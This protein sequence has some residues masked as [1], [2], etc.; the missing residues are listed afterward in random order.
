MTSGTARKLHLKNKPGG[1]APRGCYRHPTA[2]GIQRPAA[3]PARACEVIDADNAP[4]DSKNPVLVKDPVLV[5]YQPD[6]T[7]LVRSSQALSRLGAR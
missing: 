6:S 7:D 4:A 5:E 3:A 2:G 1:T